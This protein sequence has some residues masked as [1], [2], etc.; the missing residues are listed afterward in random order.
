MLAQQSLPLRLLRRCESALLR[1][2]IS[3]CRSRQR[4]TGELLA[5]MLRRQRHLRSS[6]STPKTPPFAPDVQTLLDEWGTSP[7]TNWH[8]CP[9]QQ[10]PLPDSPLPKTLDE[11]D[12]PQLELALSALH[13]A[14]DSGFSLPPSN[15][16][17]PLKALPPSEWVCLMAVWEMLQRQRDESPLQ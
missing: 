5:A 13:D 11:L 14:L 2:T 9:S 12:R 17:D 16:P 7:Q 15:L 10:Q 4:L 1:W 3:A 8:S 6:L